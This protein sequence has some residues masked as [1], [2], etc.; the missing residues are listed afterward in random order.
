MSV[1]DFYRSLW[2]MKEAG[3][4]ANANGFLIGRTMSS[5]AKDDF[6]YEDAMHQIFD[7][8]N[9]PVIY[10]VDFGHVAPQWTMVNG[11]LA[12]FQYHDGKGIM[13][14]YLK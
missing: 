3:W 12:K 1:P 7:E 14:S 5:E 6:T 2:Q 9:V 11:A 13:E 4:F 8:M 10:D